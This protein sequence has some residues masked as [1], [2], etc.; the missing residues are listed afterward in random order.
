MHGVEQVRP[1]QQAG[2]YIALFW[3]RGNE[4]RQGRAFPGP[5][6]RET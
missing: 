4:L 2:P 3:L 5:G 1:Y 6:G